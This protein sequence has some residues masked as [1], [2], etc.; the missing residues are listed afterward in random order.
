MEF[1]KAPV[2]EGVYELRQL[3][4]LVAISLENKRF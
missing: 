3:L 1:A 2:L 4:L